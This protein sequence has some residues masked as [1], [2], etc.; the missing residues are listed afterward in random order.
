MTRSLYRCLLWLHPPSF[1]HQFAGEMLWIFDEASGR[2]G[3]G[4]L[5]L[6]G[7]ISLSRQWILNSRLWTVAGAVL[8]GFLPILWAAA[9]APHTFRKL[10]G[11]NVDGTHAV[12]I[13]LVLAIFLAIS[14]TVI[15]S[16]A[17]FRFVRHHRRA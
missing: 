6:D 13:V 2:E 4:P 3:A 11:T 17:L 14:M 16:V 8:G 5:L 12:F 7:L 1:R 9:I 10:N 15:F